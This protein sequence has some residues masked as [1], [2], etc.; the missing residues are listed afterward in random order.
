M[1]RPLN[2]LTWQKLNAASQTILNSAPNPDAMQG[3]IGVD[4][5]LVTPNLSSITGTGIYIDSVANE[6][7]FLRFRGI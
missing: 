1:A 7:S 6:T 4:A 2:V 5:A 3:A